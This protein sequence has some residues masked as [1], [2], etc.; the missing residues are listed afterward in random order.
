LTN[1][2]FF[3]PDNASKFLNHESTWDWLIT[4]T[5]GEEAR[6]SW[7]A[8]CLPNVSHIKICREKHDKPHRFNV[9]QGSETTSVSWADL[10]L[11]L[12]K[13]IKPSDNILI[14]I[15]MLGFEAMLYL[16]PA[17]SK[18]KPK[19]LHAIYAVPKNY[20]FTEDGDSHLDLQPIEQPKGYA[21]LTGE[22]DRQES[23]HILLLGFDKGRPWK[24]IEKYDWDNKHIHLI[25]GSPSFVERGV[26]HAL[27]SCEPWIDRFQDKY[28]DHVH[29][30]AAHDIVQLSTFLA[31]CLEGSQWLDIVP[32]GPKPMLLGVL[33]FYLGLDPEVRA[34]VRILY[35]FPEQ[36]QPRSTDVDGIW[37]YNCNHFI[38]NHL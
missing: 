33:G 2:T 10:S 28:Q 18:L 12:S 1:S 3:T 22:V 32:L 6:A 8:D 9:T 37:L 13:Y 21:T 17:I 36:H 5:K 30:I 31:S 16:I 27:K 7:C 35:D 25:I 4:S 20:T 19:E 38:S 34:R 15:T 29:H 26:E 23:L 14:D 11:L 24:F